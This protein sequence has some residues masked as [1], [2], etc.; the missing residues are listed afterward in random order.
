MSEANLDDHIN[1]NHGLEEDEEQE[2]EKLMA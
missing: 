2:I 1:N